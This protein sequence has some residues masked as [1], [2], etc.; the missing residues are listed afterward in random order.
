MPLTDASAGTPRLGA[1]TVLGCTRAVAIG[2]SSTP[3]PPQPNNASAA[4]NRAG[5]MRMRGTRS[6]MGVGRLCRNKCV[7]NESRRMER[8]ENPANARDDPRRASLTV[9]SPPKRQSPRAQPRA[10]PNPRASPIDRVQRLQ[11]LAG[12][13]V[14]HQGPEKNRDG[15]AV[16][17]SSNSQIRRTRSQPHEALLRERVR[18]WCA[19]ALPGDVRSRDFE[20]SPC[21]VVSG[22]VGG[23]AACQRVRQRKAVSAG[24]HECVP[25]PAASVSAPTGAAQECGPWPFHKRL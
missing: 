24:F 5:R 7:T 12:A 25:V 3:P 9:G 22:A 17:H 1:K 19:Q 23:C 15:R 14:H 13:W 8:S 2:V 11:R 6:C 20:Q 16:A 10:N 18:R 21:G 4:A